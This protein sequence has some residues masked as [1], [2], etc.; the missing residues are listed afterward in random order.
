MKPRIVVVGSL[1]VDV[2]ARVPSLPAA[3]ETIFATQVLERFGGKGANQALAASRLGAEVTLIGAVGD[4]GH[5]RAYRAQWRK[6]GLDDASIATIPHVP[7]GTASIAVDGRGENQI[8]VHAG[9]NGRVTPR[10]LR[11][12]ERAFRG[13]SIVLLQA[14]VPLPAIEEAMRLALHHGAQIMF[15][16]SPW[17]ADFH[18]AGREI[19]CV[20]LNENEARR[21]RRRREILNTVTTHG[22]K[23]TL[24][25]DPSG[26]TREFAV[27]QLPHPVVDTVGAGDTFAGALAVELASGGDFASAIAF[28]NCAAGLATLKVGAQGAM[29]RRAAVMRRMRGTLRGAP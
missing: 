22:A 25:V 9:A 11:A 15:N 29:P 20:V 18:W 23:P 21:L 17:P 12:Q 3:G 5:G 19:F 26:R 13:A 16:P 8:I 27:P 4:D 14:E 1:N 6:Y 24:W 2:I 7:T 10:L 28:A